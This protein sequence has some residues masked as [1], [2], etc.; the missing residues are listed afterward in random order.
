[1]GI[2][3]VRVWC[4]RGPGHAHSLLAHRFD[5]HRHIAFSLD[6]RDDSLAIYLDGYLGWKGS[7]GSKVAEADCGAGRGIALGRRHPGWKDALPVGVGH[8]HW[9]VGQVLSEAKVWGLAHATVAGLAAEDKCEK[10]REVVDKQWKDQHGHDCAWFALH[11]HI[12]PSI[13]QLEEPREMCPVA[14]LAYQPCFVPKAQAKHYQLWHT[15][16]TITKKTRKGTICLDS[17]GE[18][19]VARSQRLQLECEEWVERGM[20]SANQQDWLT[21]CR[22]SAGERL[23]L[24]NASTVCNEVLSA[25]DSE[26]GFEASQMRQ[27][28]EDVAKSGGDFSVSFWYRPVDET[29]LLGGRFLP[30]IAFYSSLFPPEHSMVLGAFKANPG[31]SLLPLVRARSLSLA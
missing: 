8:L 2:G 14:C 17:E 5:A 26:C 3:R 1:M 23:D 16:Q 9:Y 19:F 18:D 24:F 21:N 11:R 7:W 25:V 13:C 28:S 10:G 27:F 12:S 29:S 31:R 22:D 6:D 20:P 30:H 4:V 15:T